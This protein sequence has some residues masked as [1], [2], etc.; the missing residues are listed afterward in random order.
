MQNSRH[1]SIHSATSVETGGDIYPISGRKKSIIPEA[2]DTETQ[3]KA[4]RKPRG[5]NKKKKAVVELDVDGTVLS[6][7]VSSADMPPVEAPSHIP[8]SM[9]FIEPLKISLPDISSLPSITAHHVD[10]EDYD[11]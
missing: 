9:P 6:T 2:A 5:P 4:P 11:S 3:G 7:D 10:E 8:E 1:S